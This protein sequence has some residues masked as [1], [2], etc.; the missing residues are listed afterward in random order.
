MRPPDDEVPFE[1]IRRRPKTHDERDW[2]A[3]K[4]RIQQKARAKRAQRRYEE[5]LLG[6]RAA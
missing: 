2:E 6:K 3:R 4:D 5:R 1:P